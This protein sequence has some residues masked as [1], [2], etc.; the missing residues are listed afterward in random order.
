MRMIPQTK[1]IHFMKIFEIMNLRGDHYITFRLSAITL[2]KSAV[3]IIKPPYN[4]VFEG[5]S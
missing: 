2:V 1:I 3:K 4:V 5:F